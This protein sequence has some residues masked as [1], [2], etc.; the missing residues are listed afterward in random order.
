MT[1]QHE[2]PELENTEEEQA[3]QFDSASKEEDDL[4][5]TWTNNV[6]NLDEGSFF[7]V[8]RLSRFG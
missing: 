2:V 7:Y 8:T 4:F 1:E 6:A 3:D 5:E